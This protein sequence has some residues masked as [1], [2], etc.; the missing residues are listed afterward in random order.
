M[1]RT[2][3]VTGNY[4][5]EIDESNHTLCELRP[6]VEKDDGSVTK[7]GWKVIGYYSNMANA[8][9][10]VKSLLLLDGQSVGVVDHCMDLVS[11]AERSYETLKVL[12]KENYND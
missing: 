3:Q 1:K 6:A 5:I 4:M 11:S 2:V 10:K 8:L 12:L 9:I 7:S